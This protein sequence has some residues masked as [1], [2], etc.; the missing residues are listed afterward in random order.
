MRQH[1]V[2]IVSG[3]DPPGLNGCGGL[4][5]IR[6]SSIPESL[7]ISLESGSRRANQGFFVAP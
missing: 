6:A 5:V 4:S 2:S 3:Q 7:E 1:V